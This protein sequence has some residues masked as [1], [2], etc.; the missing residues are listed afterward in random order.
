MEG[1]RFREGHP[2]NPPTKSRFHLVGERV[3]RDQVI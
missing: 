2:I 1:D 3:P